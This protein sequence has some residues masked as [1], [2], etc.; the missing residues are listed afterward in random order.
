LLAFLAACSSGPQR[1]SP[2][3]LPPSPNLIGVRQAWNTS[4]AEV[5]SPIDVKVVGQTVALASADGTISVLDTRTGERLWQ[6]SAGD[7]LAAGVGYDGR[8]AAIMTR[9]NELVVV[10]AG[11]ELWRQRLTAPSFTSPMVAGSRV[12]VLG[13]DRAVTAFDGQTGR[14]IW[15]QQR[16]GEA[17]V[18]RQAGVLLAVGDTLVAGLSGKLVGLNPLT[19]SV[20]WE[21]AIASPRGTNDVER[22]VDLV[23]PASRQGGVVCAR[24]F[25]TSVGCVDAVRGSVV[26]TKPA[27]GS[28]GLNGDEKLVIG[29][30]SD[31]TLAAWKRSNGERAWTVEQLRYRNLTAPLVVGRSVVLGEDNGTLHF[32]SIDD[33]SVQT[34]VGTDGSAI[35]SAPVLAGNTLI[36]VTRRGGVF[37]FRPE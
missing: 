37:G 19:G 31:G 22:L 3:D 6:A 15:T 21:A 2:A 27:A 28:I 9:N 26:W 25:Q 36:A 29:V 12:F 13:S 11:R 1:P 16:P 8:L 17:L 34:R 32:L 10:E 5:T 14:K 4:I 35:E 30:E 20:R 7:A 33:G 23:A 18:L 24:A